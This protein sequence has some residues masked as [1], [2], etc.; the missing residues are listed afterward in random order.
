MR[1]AQNMR[2]YVWDMQKQ[3]KETE[4]NR[5]E[6]FILDASENGKYQITKIVEHSETVAL[7]RHMGYKVEFEQE[8]GR[9][10]ISW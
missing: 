1:D 5:I 8:A 10:T 6:E 3:R 2:Q 4:I 7:L 9:V